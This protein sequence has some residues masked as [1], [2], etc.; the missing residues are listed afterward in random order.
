[1]KTL[2]N[3]F[4]VLIVSILAVSCT[5]DFDAPPFTEPTYTGPT[6]NITIADFKK[7]YASATTTPTV[8]DS[9]WIIR[10]T[11]VGNDVSGNIYKQMYIQDS[12]GGIVVGID[13]NSIYTNYKAGQEIYLNLQ[14]LAVLTYGGEI[15]IGYKGTGSTR[16]PW[17]IFTQ[18]AQLNGWPDTTRF[19]P[20]KVS[21][22]TLSDNVK[23]I[24]VEL[25]SVY[26]VNEGK[27]QFAVSTALSAVSQTLKDIN[28][29][30][31][32]LRTSVYADF[33]ADSLPVGY[34]KLVGILSKYNGSWQFTLRSASDIKEFSG[35]TAVFLDES[36]MTQDSFNRFTAYSVTGSQIWGLSTSYGAMITGYVSGTNYANEDWLISPASDLS[37]KS[38]AT[39]SFSHASGPAANL[40]VGK[41]LGYYTVWV[42]N[43]YTSGAPSTATWTELTGITYGTS[44]WSYKVSTLTI[45]AANMKPNLRFAFRYMSSNTQSATW[46][47]KNVTLR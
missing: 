20:K 40:F 47:I 39:L 13:Q 11:V 2:R 8:M 19:T 7:F 34:G 17:D 1:M 23:N 43:D 26:F 45:P 5:R 28:G 14:G 32:D 36:L 42:S 18:K 21:L 16:V 38:S 15:Q 35:E 24:L 3:I 9:A 44:A 12:T 33:A 41:D 37:K 31:V 25:D 6:N 10:A 4:Y 30:S 29:N 22:G 27:G 46:E